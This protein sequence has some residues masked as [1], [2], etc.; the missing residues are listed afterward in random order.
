MRNAILLSILLLSVAS[1]ASHPP[2]VALGGK[3]FQV[4]LARS[5]SEHAL[6]LMYRKS[7]DQDRGMLFIFDEDAPRSFWMKNTLIPLD[8]VFIAGDGRIVSIERDVMPCRSDPC[9]S[10]IGGPAR[11]VL[12]VAANQS[13][14]VREG[15]LAVISVS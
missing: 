10:V 14:D 7:L 6:G 15:D 3:V 9:P 1:C 2:S 4:E 12:E 8:M 11:Y 13:V 5:P